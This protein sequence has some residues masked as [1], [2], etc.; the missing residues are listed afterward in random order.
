V[1]VFA[2]VRGWEP[3]KP[4]LNFEQWPRRAQRP[5]GFSPPCGLSAQRL[6]SFGRGGA[7]LPE[8]RRFCPT[9]LRTSG[10]L[11]ANARRSPRPGRCTARDRGPAGDSEPAR[12]LR[13]SRIEFRFGW[14]R[15]KRSGNARGLRSPGLTPGPAGRAPMAGCGDQASIPRQGRR[16][17]PVRL[18]ADI[19]QP[20]PQTQPAPTRPARAGVRRFG[21]SHGWLCGSAAFEGAERQAA[22]RSCRPCRNDP[23]LQRIAL[24]THQGGR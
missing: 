15:L 2:R 19:T 18:A 24:S 10:H 4:A 3:R 12:Y 21:G 6:R 11:E 9:L 17:L 1:S 22:E 23:R 14:S 5:A 16:A 7:R 20:K 13:M 8:P